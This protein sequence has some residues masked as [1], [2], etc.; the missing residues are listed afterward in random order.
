MIQVLR[1]GAPSVT[2]C[3]HSILCVVLTVQQEGLFV[4]N[5]AQPEPASGAT[6]ADDGRTAAR[7][8]P[9]VRLRQADSVGVPSRLCCVLRLLRICPAPM[10]LLL[11][12]W[13]G[14]VCAGVNSCCVVFFLCVF[15]LTRPVISVF[16]SC[17]LLLNQRER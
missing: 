14:C 9:A 5:A 13:V 3:H 15:S 2:Y 11:H 4:G 10:A 16:V 17:C 12:S 1:D 7:P 8:S 6:A